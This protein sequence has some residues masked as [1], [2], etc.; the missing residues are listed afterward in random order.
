MILNKTD[1]LIT[2]AVLGLGEGKMLRLSFSP[3]ESLIEDED[4]ERIKD[5]LFF[6]SGDLALGQR[7]I[8]K[9]EIE[10]PEPEKKMPPIV[11]NQAKSKHKGGRR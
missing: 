3:G 1:H 10:Q 6:K 7:A 9:K 8:E 4:Y 2:P 5:D 11:R